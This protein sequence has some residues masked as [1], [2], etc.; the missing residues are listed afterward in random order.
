[1]GLFD[2][3]AP[4]LFWIDNRAA[5]IL[6]PLVRLILWGVIGA[7]V[8]MLLYRALSP[9]DRIARDKRE[10]RD[11]RRDL[12]EF[13]GEFAD[14]FP[15]IRRLLRLSLQQV[16]RVG[17]PAVVAS[18][19]LLFLLG[20][21]ST[22]YAYG[23]PPPGKTP[24]IKTSPSRLHAEWVANRNSGRVPHVVV[25]DGNQRI[26]AD[27]GLAAPVPVVHKRQWWNLL[28]GNPVGYLPD[29]AAVDEI[30]ISLPQKTYLPFGPAWMRGW[31]LTFFCSLVLVSVFIK[32]V[33]GIE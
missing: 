29:D 22:A 28:I 16:G 30:R 7:V 4:V 31:E 17:W 12:D 33:A 18:L 27:I 19:P 10:I 25:A 9:Q 2:A 21:L 32:V 11:A 1:M 24:E 20:W 6:P 3:A 15:L 8:S 26:V 13:D 23:Y 5:E 14:A